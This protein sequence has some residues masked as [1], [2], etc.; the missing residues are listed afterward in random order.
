MLY[1]SKFLTV[2]DFGLI[3]A[4]HFERS[5]W[6]QDVADILLDLR[7]DVRDKARFLGMGW[8]PNGFF[9]TTAGETGEDF[10]T[11]CLQAAGIAS[12]FLSLGLPLRGALCS[13]HL[14]DELQDGARVCFGPA[15]SRANQLVQ[16]NSVPRIAIDPE[17]PIS[18]LPDAIPTDSDGTKYLDV[19][20]PGFLKD[21]WALHHRGRNSTE[22]PQIDLQSTARL[23]SQLRK[24]AGQEGGQMFAW[25]A[26]FVERQR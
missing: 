26:N 1:K 3:V 25:L 4:A 12:R 24:D 23:I 15:A 8:R 17:I 13:G 18:G 19:F 11:A 5:A 16:E 14:V 21:Y 22:L 6:L 20:D 9:L 10:Y 2:F 7:A